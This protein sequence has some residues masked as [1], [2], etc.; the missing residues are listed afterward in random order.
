[1]NR[2]GNSISSQTPDFQIV[3]VN[4]L[5]KFTQVIKD[6]VVTQRSRESFQSVRANRKT[7]KEVLQSIH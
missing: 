3:N 1:M 4:N 7:F 6:F 2:Q 5:T